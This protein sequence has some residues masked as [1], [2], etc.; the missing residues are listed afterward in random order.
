MFNFVLVFVQLMVGDLLSFVVVM[1]EWVC[2]QYEFVV[3]IL[4]FEEVLLFVCIVVDEYVE[5]DFVQQL[6]VEIVFW[7]LCFVIV[8]CYFECGMLFFELCLDLCFY[9]VVSFYEVG[10]GDVVCC[11]FEECVDDVE[12]FLWVDEIKNWILEELCV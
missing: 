7:V 3:R 2:K 5:L 11:V 1:F 10:F 8:L 4:E 12:L 9:W 6:I